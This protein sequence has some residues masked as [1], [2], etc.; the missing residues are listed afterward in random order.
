MW[1]SVYL[2]SFC[3]SFLAFF[4]IHKYLLN[5]YS[6]SGTMLDYVGHKVAEKKDVG[7]AH[8]ELMVYR[9]REE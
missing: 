9:G 8:M 6:V 2:F 5:I 7:L 4:L 3:P 1:L